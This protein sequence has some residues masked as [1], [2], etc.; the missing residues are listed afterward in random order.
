MQLFPGILAF[1]FLK[2]YCVSS[3]VLG[4]ATLFTYTF[5]AFQPYKFKSD[6]L[7]K[8]ITIKQQRITIWAILNHPTFC[9]ILLIL[10]KL[11]FDHC[12]HFKDYIYFPLQSHEAS[13]LDSSHQPPPP[14]S[15]T[16]IYG[17][18]S[19]FPSTSSQHN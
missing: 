11:Y 5:F 18:L 9:Y 15:H 8:T 16:S 14:H 6:F 12:Y 2:N 13:S 17:S 19:P 10:V 3:T 4:G 7:S 1:S